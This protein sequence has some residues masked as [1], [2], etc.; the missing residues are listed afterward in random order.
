MATTFLTR[1]TAIVALVATA[2]LGGGVA[3]AYPSGTAM[4][5]AAA[6][7][8]TSGNNADVMVTVSNANPACQLLVMVD[9]APSALLPAGITTHTFTVVASMGRHSVR[10]RTVDCPKGQKEHAKSKYVILNAQASHLG[11]A[12]LKKNYAVGYSGLQPADVL[13]VTA[14]LAGSSPLEQMV[15]TDTVDRRGNAKI[16]FKFRTAGTWS[17]STSATPSGA[18]VA[19]FS[20][21]VS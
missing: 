8:A 18:S 11:T 14:T 15:K 3:Y 13:T 10:A 6:A 4:T 12:T 20:V 5:V 1:K 21:T 9:G 16:K 7:A 17:I 19:P 2:G